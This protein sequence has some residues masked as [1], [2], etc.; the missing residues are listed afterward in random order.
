MRAQTSLDK[1]FNSEEVKAFYILCCQYIKALHTRVSLLN[2]FIS[3]P[4]YEARANVFLVIVKKSAF[5]PILPFSRSCRIYIFLITVFALDVSRQ[6][7]I[8]SVVTN[9]VNKRTSK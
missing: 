6:L 3:N 2:Y 9:T 7:N 4:I 5:S 1:L 8:F